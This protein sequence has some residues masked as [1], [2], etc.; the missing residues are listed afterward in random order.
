MAQGLRDMVEIRDRRDLPFFQV[1][2]TAVS[3]IRTKVG[4]PR[5]VRAIGFYALLCQL[6][7]EQRHTGEHRVIQVNYEELANRGQMSKG[8]VKTLLDILVSA[9]VVR[10]ERLADRERG[11]TIS[12]LHL[13]VH[14]G[15]WTPITVAMADRLAEARPTGHLLRDLGLVVVL[16]EFCC[17]QR[18]QHGGLRA[19]VM[20]ADIAERAGL[21]VDRVDDCN[22]VL[23]QAGVLEIRRRRATNGGRNLAS[24]Y[25]IIEATAD[26]AQ[27]GA[28]EPAARQ[29][30][31]SRAE[32]GY[33]QG[34]TTVLV[35]Q[36]N[37][38]GRAEERYRQDGV[39]A[40][41]G[42]A[43]PGSFTRAGGIS[44]TAVEEHPLLSSPDSG[45]SGEISGPG[46]R[47]GVHSPEQQLCQALVAAWE[48]AL[49]GI[50]QGSFDNDRRRW[51]KA[52]EGLLQR[53]PRERLDLALAYMVGDEILG[54]EALTMPG[55]SKVADKLIA[56]A[57]ARRLRL[58]ARAAPGGT[59]AGMGW[60]DARIKLEQAIK[61]HGRDGRA[62]ALSELASAS[63]LLLK[64]VERV[65]WTELC[66]Q[67]MRY[68][69]RQYAD[70]WA[71]I[72][73]QANDTTERA[74]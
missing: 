74:A 47:G 71:E 69:E 46:G 58:G 34:G 29:N 25:T 59:G 39:S 63:P 5:R 15:Q 2:L 1:R 17:R 61:R 18:D 8:S 48:P 31:T 12:F 41:D 21:T 40:N 66:E 44:E 68:V 6:A 20:R 23:E 62:A 51:L 60:Q 42:T 24:M 57:H 7:N 43:A 26:Q 65:R 33:Q 52:A 30:S 13:L 54:S 49:G 4:G 67:P 64:F 16:L 19:E 55:F 73:Q 32:D 35:P 11:A 22:R 10:Y 36:R 27:G 9:G 53:H 38:T 56:R 70:I 50:P 3:E 72:T 28:S 45:P 14:D 37:G